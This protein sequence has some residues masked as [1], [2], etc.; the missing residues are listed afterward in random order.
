MPQFIKEAKFFTFLSWISIL[1]SGVIASISLGESFLDTFN[2]L[3]ESHSSFKYYG[4]CSFRE[5]PLSLGIHLILMIFF[6][7]FTFGIQITLFF[8]QR[9]LK[10]ERS[11][12]IMVI[13][14]NH[15]GVTIS[16]RCADQSL[17]HKLINFDRT[18]VSPKASFFLFLSNFLRLSL[19][20]ILL[21]IDGPLVPS[22][23]SQFAVYLDFCVLF[24]LFTLVE[25]Y[26][27][28]TLFNT[29]IDYIP[30]HNREYIVP[31][32]V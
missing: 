7:L 24:F 8:K 30:W 13:T 32:N 27:S 6:V 21:S 14:Y 23:I 12:G 4:L 9:Q 19:H 10:K 29:I 18:V 20:I 22:I 11:S 15:D 3:N 16:R 2:E 25:H 1:L 5:D 31:V 28:P 26:F 17:G